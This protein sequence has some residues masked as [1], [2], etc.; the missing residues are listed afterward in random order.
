[1]SE[2]TADREVCEQHHWVSHHQQGLPIRWVERCSMCG[3]FNN[4]H[5]AEEL[6]EVERAAAEKAWDEGY[7][8]C[9]TYHTSEGLQGAT[10]NPFKVSS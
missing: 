6:A 2:G 8:A 5:L 10:E 1:M 3:D 9:W 7:G 4:A